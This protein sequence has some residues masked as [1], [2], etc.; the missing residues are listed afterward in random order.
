MVV[1]K[2][3][4]P[5]EDYREDVWGCVRCNWCKE[6]F[7]W[8]QRSARFAYLCPSWHK[9]GFDA[10]SA[11]GRMD[12]ARALIEGEMDW[13]DSE[14]L[15]EIIYSCTSCGACEMNCLRLQEHQPSRVVEALKV[16]A[17]E[18]GLGPMPRQRE[19]AA[20][21]EKEHNPYFERHDD[22][23]KWLPSDVKLTPTADTAYFV[24]CTSSYRRTEIAIATVRLLN[25]LGI[26][27]KLLHPDEWCCGSPLFRIGMRRQAMKLME[28]NVDT[29]R[30]LGV[31]K[32]IV[33][34]AGCYRAFKGDYPE[35]L[36]D[37]PFEVLHVTEVAAEVIKEGKV[38][39]GEV[40]KVVTYHDPC[41]MARHF[42]VY[43]PPREILRNIPG[44]KFIEMER[45]KS[46]SWCCGAGGGVKSAFPD[47]ALWAASERLEEV[48]AVGAHTLVSACPFCA[49]NFKDAI[50]AKGLD[51]EFMDITELLIE[52]IT[53][54][55]G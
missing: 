9:F 25:A 16:R 45:V 2:E 47:L 10:Y 8:Y 40:N 53:K 52:S 42:G 36:G 1:F 33:S 26:D 48:M 46:Q 29:L 15:L 11:Q 6:V 14:K 37:L 20:H 41:H 4:R 50:K 12:I 51:L 7:G 43:E 21:I 55:G 31:K 54:G 24:G 27:F 3:L 39:L 35:L 32:L 30:R 49:T 19:W 23:I 34:C 5:L 28:H 44:L 22:R 38:K 13:R 17:V 18:L